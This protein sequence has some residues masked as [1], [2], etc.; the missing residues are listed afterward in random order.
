MNKV[1][2]IDKNPEMIQALRDAF[3][4]LD[5]YI[6]LEFHCRSVTGSLKADAIISCSNSGGFLC[7]GIDG[8]YAQKWPF[9]QQRINEKI[10][11]TFPY[12]LPVGTA[13]IVAL[14]DDVKYFVFTPTMHVPGTDLR[15][16]T[17][18]YQAMRAA[19]IAIKKNKNIQTVI[20]PGMGT[21]VGNLDYE[22]A[23][24]QMAEGLFDALDEYPKKDLRHFV[25][26]YDSLQFQNEKEEVSD[27]DADNGE[28]SQEFTPEVLVDNWP[29]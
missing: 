8:A 9:L 12:E 27:R 15:G 5:D 17:N 25:E 19:F 1:I 29:E 14:S 10:L 11:N 23:A 18:V 28:G 3:Q 13:E 6:A 2:F 4:G 16:T 22:V 20:C 7:G 24:N 21:G 26:Y